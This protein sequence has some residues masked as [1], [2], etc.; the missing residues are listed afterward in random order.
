MPATAGSVWGY[1]TF[2]AGPLLQGM[3][4]CGCQAGPGVVRGREGEAV[5]G[6]EG[7]RCGE[8]VWHSILEGREV[9]RLLH[10]N[11]AVFKCTCG[12][13]AMV[14][15]GAEMSLGLAEALGRE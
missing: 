1:G 6:V 10:W 14:A 3:H 11:T 2:E 9:R 5:G 15:T 7:Q 8:G 12:N 4:V 13:L